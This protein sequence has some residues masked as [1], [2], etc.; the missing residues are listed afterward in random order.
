MNRTLEQRFFRE[1]QVG[2]AAIMALK[3]AQYVHCGIGSEIPAR[4]DYPA[5]VLAEIKERTEALDVWPWDGIEN[6][7]PLFEEIT[8]N[9]DSCTS[10]NAKIS[11][12]FRI[13][14]QFQLWTRLYSLSPEKLNAIGRSVEKDSLEDFFSDW[15][16]A[17]ATFAKKLAVVLAI[18]DINILD[19]QKKCGV[20]IIDNLDIDAL[21]MYFGSRELAERS[22]SKFTSKNDSTRPKQENAVPGEKGRKTLPFSDVLLGTPDTKQKTLERLHLLIDGKKGKAVALVIHACKSKGLMTEPTFTQVKNEFGETVGNRSGYNHYIRNKN[23]YKP[24]EIEDVAKNFDDI[25]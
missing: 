9:L 21:W 2:G 5:G 23:L 19:I 3:M 22:L 8:D 6:V 11:Y 15:R 12:V 20:S 10:G 4:K 24:E 16:D 18:L 17:F 25:R 13:L 7:C 1:F 14:K